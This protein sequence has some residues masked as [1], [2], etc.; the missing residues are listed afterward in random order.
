M[1][2]RIIKLIIAV[3]DYIVAELKR[4][5][6]ETFLTHSFYTEVAKRKENNKNKFIATMAKLEFVNGI[7][8]KN[9]KSMKKCV[10]RGKKLFNHAK[11]NN[12]LDE[13]N[14]LRKEKYE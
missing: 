9:K 4:A 12:D 3:L 14:N 5:Y 1:C 7:L 11:R 6:A 8:S 10:E 2:E 13:L